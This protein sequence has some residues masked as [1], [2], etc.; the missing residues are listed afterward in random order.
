MADFWDRSDKFSLVPILFSAFLVLFIATLFFVA[1]GR[2]PSQLPLLYSLP[3]GQ[4]QLVAKQQ[5]LL[6][7]AVLALI[8]LVNTLIASQLHPVQVVVKRI[9]SLSLLLIDLIIFITALKIIFI[10]F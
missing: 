4:T 7:P 10:F 1:Y 6:L 2:L 5:F 3:W 9:L 8:T